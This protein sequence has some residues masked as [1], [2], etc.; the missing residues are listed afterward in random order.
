MLKETEILYVRGSFQ[1]I[2]SMSS[3]LIDYMKETGACLISPFPEI[4]E[5]NFLESQLFSSSLEYRGLKELNYV[6]MI[7][8]LSFHS[9]LRNEEPISITTQKLLSREEIYKEPVISFSDEEREKSFIFSSRFKDMKPLCFFQP[10]SLSYLGN[11]D[12]TRRSLSKD[13]A[14]KILSILK[15]KFTVIQLKTS[16][17]PKLLDCSDEISLDT[18]SSWRNLFFLSLSSHFM[19][20]V[21]C[22]LNPLSV[23][24]NKKSI[25]LWS[26][27]SEQILGHPSSFNIRE[28]EKES[29]HASVAE[30]FPEEKI[31]FLNER[32]NY[33]SEKTLDEIENYVNKNT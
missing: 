6:R 16:K 2:L 20:S 3:C 27:T 18:I 23:A 13:F 8:P 15:K 31:V 9:L 11:V 1:K 24:L 5:N 7:D 32:E 29:I 17:Q 22:I 14:E 30:S 33:F 10:F 26:S 25:V 12:R 21:D 4:F 19:I 28:C